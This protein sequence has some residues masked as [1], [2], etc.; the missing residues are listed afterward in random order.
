MTTYTEILNAAMNLSPLEREE[1]ST[2]SQSVIDERGGR[3]RPALRSNRIRQSEHR[4]SLCRSSRR[5]GKLFELRTNAGARRRASSATMTK[6]YPLRR[7]RRLPRAISIT[8]NAAA[9]WREVRRPSEGAFDMIA[10][11]PKGGTVYNE[12]STG[13][14]AQRLSASCSLRI[15]QRHG[16]RDCDLS[17]EP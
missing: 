8:P 9:T 3:T 17:S 11:N 12:K 15:R 1:L 6:C 16:N 13:L 10:F 7:G 2:L 5:H 4:S 14:F